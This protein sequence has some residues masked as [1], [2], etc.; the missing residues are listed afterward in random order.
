MHMLLPVIHLEGLKP[1]EIKELWAK[2]FKKGFTEASLVVQR[3]GLCTPNTGGPGVI[4]GQGTGSHMPP[5]R[6]L[7]PQLEI[8]HATMKMEDL[9]GQN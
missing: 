7:K 6:L 5:L 1:K 8:L 3:L 9:K 4:P 2:I